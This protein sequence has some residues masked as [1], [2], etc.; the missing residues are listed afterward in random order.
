[1]GKNDIVDV[2]EL[3]PVTVL[4]R[5]PEGVAEVV[6]DVVGLIKNDFVT[7]TEFVPDALLV[8]DP[9]LVSCPVDVLLFTEELVYVGRKD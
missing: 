2:T 7:V 4:V 5:D 1:M 9:L 6:D 8:T 3:V